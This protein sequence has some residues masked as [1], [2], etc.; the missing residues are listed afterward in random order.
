MPSMENALQSE[1]RPLSEHASRP[2]STPPR[3]WDPSRQLLESLSD[4]RRDKLSGTKLGLIK[5]K[6]AV[7]RH[8]FWS[9]VT[10]ADIPLNTWGLGEE[11]L[12]EHPNGIVI[13][14]DVEMGPHC[15]LFQQVTLGTGPTPGVPRLGA[16]VF[17]GAGAKI[18]GGVTIGDYAVIGANAVVITDVPAGATA[19]GIPAQIKVGARSL[20]DPSGY[21]HAVQLKSSN[22]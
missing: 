8:R 2:L 22:G 15:Q 9:V 10:G 16:H 4:Y 6:V 18:L 3:Y 17:V 5:S 11:L 13:H 7:V 14:P 1:K 19:V 20:R 21:L 12:L